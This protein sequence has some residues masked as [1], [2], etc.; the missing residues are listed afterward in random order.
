MMYAL[1][2]DSGAIS[3][4]REFDGPPPRLSDG[5]PLRWL[6]VTDIAPPTPAFGE[7]LI[8]PKLLVVEDA[9]TRSWTVEPIP[10]EEFADTLQRAVGEAVQSHLDASARARG[11][12]SI[13]TCATYADEPAVA[14]FQAEGQA[15]RAWRSL[16]WAAC[17]AALDDVLAGRREPLTPSQMVAE[18]PPLVWPGD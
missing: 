7:R 3:Q 11:Y 12:E 14:R 18:L 6:P 15:A 2:T 8:G 4:L 1:V 5:K 17:Y 10:R 16:V 13:Y 9:I